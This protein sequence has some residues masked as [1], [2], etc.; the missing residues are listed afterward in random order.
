MQ[1]ALSGAKLCG[2]FHADGQA[3][4]A[5]EDLRRFL[6]GVNSKFHHPAGVDSEKDAHSRGQT[7]RAGGA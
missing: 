5:S 6:A 2:A 1:A 3:E 7:A 4:G